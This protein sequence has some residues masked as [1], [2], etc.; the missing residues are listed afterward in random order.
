MAAMGTGG[1]EGARI[2]TLR[3][4]RGLS[5]TDLAR[6]AGLSK[7]ELSKLE[8]GV[9]PLRPDHLERLA[10]ALELPAQALLVPDSPLHRLT[11]A[12][13]SGMAVDGTAA[14]GPAAAGGIP[15][16]DGR[17]LA[18]LGAR[19]QPVGRVDTPIPLKGVDGAYAVV[20]ND[21]SNAPVLMPGVVLHVNPA[22][23]PAPGDLVINSQGWSPLAFYLRQDDDGRFYGLTLSRRRVELTQEAVERLH[24]VAGLWFVG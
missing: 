18:R 23:V 12:P 6:R 24:K 4:Q 15:L 7:G 19:A 20:I 13:P 1:E 3:Q 14:D 8:T 16:Y 2:R 5:L 22:R 11:A 9:R 17:D 21:L 10:S